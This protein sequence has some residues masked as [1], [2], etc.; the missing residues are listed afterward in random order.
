MSTPLSPI[1]LVSTDGHRDTD[2]SPLR[3]Q[4]WV[5]SPRGR[6]RS[7][8][9]GLGDGVCMCNREC[10]VCM[11]ESVCENTCVCVSLYKCVCVSV[12]VS[13]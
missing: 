3:T 11:C 4:V 13:V 2:H 12:C 10:V 6:W 9:W 8:E 1:L 7:G 5:K